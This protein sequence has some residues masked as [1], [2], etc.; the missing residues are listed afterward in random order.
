MSRPRL[1]PRHPTDSSTMVAPSALETSITVPQD[2]SSV[3]EVAA[4][5]LTMEEARTTESPT[6]YHGLE[7]SSITS[8]SRRT[9]LESSALTGTRRTRSIT[10]DDATRR[11]VRTSPMV[12]HRLHW[13]KGQRYKPCVTQSRSSMD[14]IEACSASCC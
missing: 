4:P 11:R 1:C 12:F 10:S 9:V 3:I 2:G 14:G 5:S 7:F 8:I 6:P 13:F